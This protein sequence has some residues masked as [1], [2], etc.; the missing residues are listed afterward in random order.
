MAVPGQLQQ[1]LINLLLN[2]M[3]AMP[4]GGQVRVRTNWGPLL[5]QTGRLRAAAHPKAGKSGTAGK[6]VDIEQ[7]VVKRARSV[8]IVVED[9]GPG[10]PPEVRDNIFDPFFS[11]K[12]NGT[13]LGLAVSYGILAAHGGDLVLCEKDGPGACFQMILPEEE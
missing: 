7:K 6:P 4:E 13:G 5:P 11:T 3:E 9:T 2:A 8:K 1:V 10:V 12:A